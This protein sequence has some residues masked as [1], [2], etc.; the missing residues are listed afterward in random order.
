MTALADL[1]SYKHIMAQPEYY[2]SVAFAEWLRLKGY[3]FSHIA[4]ETRT[5]FIGTRMKNKRMGVSPGLLDY[6]IVIPGKALLWV[7]MKVKK[8][9]VSPKQKKWVEALNSVK[10]SEATVCYSAQE[11]IEFVE[12]AQKCLDK[13]SV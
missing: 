11:A 13:L 2:E 10:N 12:T 1:K 5:P 8:G 3:R 9:R 6:L 7:E 4:N